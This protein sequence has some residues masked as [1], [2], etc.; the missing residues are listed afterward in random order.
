MRQGL[1]E[2]KYP[3]RGRALNVRA[4]YTEQSAEVIVGED[5]TVYNINCMV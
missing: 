5:T 2:G 1:D 4:T 3:Y